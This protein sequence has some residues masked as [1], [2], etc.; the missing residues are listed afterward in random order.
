MI[1]W[2]SLVTA[3]FQDSVIVFNAWIMPKSFSSTASLMAS[4]AFLVSP[5]SCSCNADKCRSWWILLL[6]TCV[7]CFLFSG[8]IFLRCFKSHYFWT[9]KRIVV[10]A[11][12]VSER[13]DIWYVL[14]LLRRSSG[15]RVW[16]FFQMSM[17][18]TSRYRGLPLTH[19]ACWWWWPYARAL[20]IITHYPRAWPFHRGDKQNHNRKKWTRPVKCQRQWDNIHSGNT[21]NHHYT[22]STS[23][24]IWQ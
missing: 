5:S 7:R 10:T 6:S 13:Q 20:L 16:T 3:T 4:T 21:R 12:I 11:I 19:T 23:A 17:G 14:G 9:L 24:V 1:S 18:W 8:S 2:L 22:H 15:L